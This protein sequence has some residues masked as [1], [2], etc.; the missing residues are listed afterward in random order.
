MWYWVPSR[1]IRM[2]SKAE[3][4]QLK[5]QPLRRQARRVADGVRQGKRNE[6]RLYY[7]RCGRAGATSGPG[8]RDAR[9][10]APHPVS[11]EDESTYHS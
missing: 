8:V 3:P 2:E 5:T 6:P 7:G 1:L 4:Y 9:E 10:D 11:D